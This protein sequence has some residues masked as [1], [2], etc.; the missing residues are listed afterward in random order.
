MLCND[1]GILKGPMKCRMQGVIQLHRACSNQAC[2]WHYQTWKYC[3]STSRV[4]VQVLQNLR[5]RW[6]TCILLPM[7]PVLSV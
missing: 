2:M 5:V 3:Q 1:H 6:Q 7:T 4:Q